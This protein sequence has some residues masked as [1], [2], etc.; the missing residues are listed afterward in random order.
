MRLYYWT[1]WLCYHEMMMEFWAGRNAGVWLHHKEQVRRC[2][3][4]IM[5]SRHV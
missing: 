5:R 2:E 3:D 1:A 4:R